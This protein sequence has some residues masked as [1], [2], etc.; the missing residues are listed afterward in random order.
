[1]HAAHVA[2]LRFGM[3]LGSG[4]KGCGEESGEKR[5]EKREE[6]VRSE[7]AHRFHSSQ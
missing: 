7:T 6:K 1:M 5:Q 2:V 3:F 4:R